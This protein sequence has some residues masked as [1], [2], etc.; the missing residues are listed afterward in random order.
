MAKAN[1]IDGVRFLV[2]RAQLTARLIGEHVAAGRMA[3][4]RTAAASLLAILR[5]IRFLGE[6]S[7]K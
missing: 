2:E 6:E 7:A 5:V 3:H 4:A 1:G